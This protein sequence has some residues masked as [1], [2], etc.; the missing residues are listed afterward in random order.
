[1]LELVEDEGQAVRVVKLAL[2]VDLRLGARLAGAVKSNWPEKTVGLVVEK[3]L[4]PLLKN[5]LLGV[6]RSEFA[7]TSLQQGLNHKDT[8]VR[9]SAVSALAQINSEKVISELLKLLEDSNPDIYISAAQGLG[10]WSCEAAIPGLRQKL[11]DIDFRKRQSYSE[12]D[13]LIWMRL[14]YALGQLSRQEAIRELRDKIR[15]SG[16]VLCGAGTLLRQL[17]GA[18]VL[19]E[20]FEALEDTSTISVHRRGLAAIVL[21]QLGNEVAIPRLL[22]ALEDA[23]SSVRSNAAE[24]LGNLGHEAAIPGLIKALAVEDEK[25]SVLKTLDKALRKL[26]REKVILEL[27]QLLQYP[28]WKIR[29]KA[30]LVLGQFGCEEALPELREGLRNENFGIRETATRVLRQLCS[31]ETIP[32]LINTLRND[33]AYCVR[34]GAAIALGQLGIEDAIPEMLKALRHYH[35]PDDCRTGTQTSVRLDSGEVIVS[36]INDEELANLGDDHAAFQWLLERNN[37]KIRIEVAE[38]LGKQGNNRATRGLLQALTYSDS[39]TRWAAA[40]V[41]GQLGREEASSELLEALRYP[42]P[43]IRKKVIAALVSIGSEE[44]IQKLITTLEDPDNSVSQSAAEALGQIGSP[45]PLSHLW[46]MRLAAREELASTIEAIQERC[47]FYNYEIAVS[48]PS[49]E[50]SKAEPLTV[51]TDMQQYEEILSVLSNM[52][53]VMERNPKTF[54]GIEEEAL[55]DHF[56]VQLNGKYKGQAT[57]ETFNK[58]GKTDILIRVD[59]KNIFIAECKFWGGEKKLKETLDQLLG[60]TAWRD[61]K[62]ALLLFNRNKNFSAVLEQISEVMKNHPTFTQEL[63]YPSETG[64]RFILHHPEDKNRELL[65]TVLAF[66]IPR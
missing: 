31:R 20:L 29:W 8:E 9:A 5:E 7:F 10:Y 23:D 63:S 22:K 57:G 19:P 64:F 1:M 32:E 58:K 48:P 38:A 65:L 52:V 46:Q 45:T 42:H 14:V 51:P 37:L 21:G 53:T 33:R 54:E 41:L 49:Q 16:F 39:L 56:L 40:I 26:S 59:G 17:D 30:T 34:R 61:T 13:F 6:T 24:A 66:E 50:K 18:E 55:R 2:E 4:P 27:R 28:S 47:K 15:I 25:D 62:L 43:D 3:E 12:K 11:A 44:V 36:G 35:L 60:Y